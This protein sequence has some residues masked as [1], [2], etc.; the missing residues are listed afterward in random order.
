MCYEKSR[1]STKYRGILK[2]SSS[3]NGL[4]NQSNKYTILKFPAM[5][6]KSGLQDGIYKAGSYGT[7][8]Y[9]INLLDDAYVKNGVFVNEFRLESKFKWG[10]DKLIDE[11]R[12]GTNIYIKTNAFSPSYDKE[13]YEPEVPPNFINKSVNVDTTEQAGKALEILFDDMKI[14]DYP[15][16][17]D[18]LEYIIN[19]VCDKDDL[20]LDFFSGS[21]TTAHAVM[22]INAKDDGKR[23]FIMAQINDNL[24][25]SLLKVHGNAKDTIAESIKF[26]ESI[27]KPHIL[28]EIGKERIK[29]AGKKILEENKEN[30]HKLDIGFRVFRLDDSNMNDVYYSP[31][32]YS[33]DLLSVLESNIKSDRNDLDLLF[34]CIL[35]WGLPLSLPYSSEY[36]DGCVVHNYNDG[37]L[38]ACFNENVPNS[39][40]KEI[41]IK[42][43]LRAVFRDSSFAD[44]PSKINVEEIFKLISPDTRI[45]VI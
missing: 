32:E 16:P 11:I 34:G 12:K 2:S 18:L 25:D 35:E 41:A 9:K 19:F 13:D 40:I 37:D 6:V 20:I 1:T 39:V 29:R 31:A 38:V 45:K 23:K 17:I 26:L 44:S 7:D 33:Q 24:D 30:T 21:A 10:Q 27:G 28:S 8:K 14:F 15:K 22:N 36:M 42:Q 43:P 4:L 3:N 5:V